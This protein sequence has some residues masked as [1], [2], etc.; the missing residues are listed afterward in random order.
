MRINEL[1]DPGLHLYQGTARE[2]AR[3][4]S[5]SDRVS[6]GKINLTGR[7]IIERKQSRI[8]KKRGVNSSKSI[9]ISTGSLLTWWEQ[10]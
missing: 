5:E 7:D 6:R 3:N 1:I 4:Q 10:F 2:L 9:K 8:F